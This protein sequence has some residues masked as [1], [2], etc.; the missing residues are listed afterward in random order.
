MG[1]GFD[2]VMLNLY[3]SGTV[4]IG[5][6]RDAKEN[7]VIAVLSL[8]A[9]RTFVMTPHV[10]SKG[11]PKVWCGDRKWTLGNGSLLVMQGDAQKNW[12]VYDSVLI[13]STQC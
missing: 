9:E 2:H 8:G 1:V 11:V 12:K 10:S 13:S 3:A 5:K 4:G 7:Q 6:H